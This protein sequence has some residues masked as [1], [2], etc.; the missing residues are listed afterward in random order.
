MRNVF[1]L[2]L[3]LAACSKFQTGFREM[4]NEEWEGKQAPP[5]EGGTWLQAGDVGKER[6]GAAEYRVLAFFKPT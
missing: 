1:L 2:L 3:A 6:F 4:R 5:I